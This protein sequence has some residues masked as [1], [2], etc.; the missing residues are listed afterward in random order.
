MLINVYPIGIGRGLV[1]HYLSLPN[2]TIIAAVRTTTNSDS[3]SLSQLPKGANSSLVLVEIDAVKEDT[4]AIAIKALKDTHEITHIDTVIANAGICTDTSTVGTVPFAV[5][6]EHVAV[7]AYG[8]VLLFQA[9]L[10]LLLKS[11]TPKFLAMGSPIG[12]VS[13]IEARPFHLGAYGMSK[14]MLHWA[15]RKISFEHS[16]IISFVIDPGLVT[17]RELCGSDADRFH[18]DLYK[19]TWGT[20][21]RKVLVLRRP[22]RHLMIV[23]LS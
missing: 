23:Q 1:A 4:P 9:V 6:K 22:L 16:E 20:R 2:H 10:P 19:A 17:Y 11:K 8:P 13:N 18:K 12:S 7:N 14:T 3:K 21:G 15:V 5:L